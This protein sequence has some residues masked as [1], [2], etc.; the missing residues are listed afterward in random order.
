M[1]RLWFIWLIAA[2][3][4]AVPA[5]GQRKPNQP[6][7][8]ASPGLPTVTAGSRTIPYH[9]RDL[10]AVQAKVRYTT[11]IQLPDGEDI[12]EATCGDKEFWIVNV[13]GSVAYVKP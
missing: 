10:V 13:H 2:T 12:V 1:T 5:L 3:T 9:P 8:S 11:L 4:M 6:G 7:V